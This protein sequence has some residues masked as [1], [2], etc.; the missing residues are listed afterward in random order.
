MFS[1]LHASWKR[2]LQCP[3]CTGNSMN[4]LGFSMQMATS[5][6]NYNQ[7]TVYMLKSIQ[8]S[9]TE[10]TLQIWGRDALPFKYFNFF[11]FS[12][13]NCCWPSPTCQLFGSFYYPDFTLTGFPC[14]TSEHTCGTIK[15]LWVQNVNAEI[16][17]ILSNFP[18]SP[19]T[20]WLLTALY[21]NVWQFLWCTD[22]YKGA[23]WQRIGSE[24]P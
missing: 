9:F 12:K 17:Q 21:L 22:T 4:H 18:K 16:Q 14:S 5:A 20:S 15:S 23:L 7:N 11:P 3:S 2:R 24:H 1:L 8:L 6:Q 19:K 10:R 13:I